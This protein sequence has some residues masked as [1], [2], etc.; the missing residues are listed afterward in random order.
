MLAVETLAK[1][2]SLLA[3]GSRIICWLPL[4]NLFQ[5]VVNLVAIRLE[6]QVFFVANPRR[7]I[8]ELL[9][10]R[11]QA[12]VAVPRF[13][14]KFAKGVREQIAQRSSFMQFLFRSAISSGRRR[15]LNG[16]DKLSRNFLVGCCDY[17]LDYLILRKIRQK[18]GG[19]IRF[20]LSG[21]SPLSFSVLEFFHCLGLPLLEAYGLTECIV[22]VAINRM[23]DFRLGSVGRPLLPGSVKISEEGEVLVK[24]AGVFGGYYSEIEES[25][26]R[27]SADGFLLTGDL[28]QFDGDGF[29]YLSGRSGDIIK[30]STGRRLSPEKIEA[31]FREV[32]YLEQ[33]AVFG[34]G[35]NQLVGLVTIDWQAAQ[36]AQELSSLRSLRELIARDLKRSSARLAHYE[37]PIGYLVL[38][39]SFSV[40][41]GELTPNLKLRRSH[42][43]KKYEKLIGELYVR[44]MSAKEEGAV[45]WFLGDDD[46]RGEV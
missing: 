33:I 38:S 26:D 24:N 1:N 41:G 40:E 23:D 34:H 30:T 14:E 13:Y 4:S 22:P 46:N 19:E 3:P 27:F 45:V 21:S 20:L 29:L 32:D 31:D 28:G 12:F 44:A 5:R 10:V 42:I 6:A 2:F 36:R 39:R 9:A 7:I 25:R 35:L 18:M 37:Q 17:V 43:G 16:H 11:P 15:Y 8:E